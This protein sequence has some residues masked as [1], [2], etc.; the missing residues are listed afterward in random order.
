MQTINNQQHQQQKQQQQQQQ[1]YIY[2]YI[3]I[4]M[5]VYEKRITI[6]KAEKKTTLP[7]IALF[8]LSYRYR[9]PFVNI[10]FSYCF[11]FTYF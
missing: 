6:I 8:R 2:I 9:L 7:P 3:H 4:Y 1:L 5:Y 10:F 11:S